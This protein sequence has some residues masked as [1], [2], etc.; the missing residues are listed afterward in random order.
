MVDVIGDLVIRTAQAATNPSITQCNHPLIH[1]P[2]PITQS[3]NLP[4][5]Q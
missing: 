1:S 5:T 4:I 2:N 3:S